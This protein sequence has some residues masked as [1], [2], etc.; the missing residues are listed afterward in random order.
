MCLWCLF[1]CG[2]LDS[3]GVGLCVFV[4]RVCLLACLFVCLFV[5]VVVFVCFDVFFVSWLVG[6][7]LVCVACVCLFVFV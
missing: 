6:R 4:L 7:L 2:W 1:A 3:L 5:F